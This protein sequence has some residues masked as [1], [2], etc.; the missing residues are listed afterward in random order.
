MDILSEGMGYCSYSINSDSMYCF[1]YSFW[2]LSWPY[3]L[4]I[5]LF[6]KLYL[7]HLDNYSYFLRVIPIFLNA[8]GKDSSIGNEGWRETV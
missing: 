6:R 2:M 8:S 5:T 3:N 7:S 4:L 1:S